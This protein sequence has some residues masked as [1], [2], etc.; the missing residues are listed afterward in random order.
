MTN[1]SGK[2][3]ISYDGRITG[4]RTIQG[5]LIPTYWDV[6]IDFFALVPEDEESEESSTMDVTIAFNVLSFW[7]NDI[8]DNLVLLDPSDVDSRNAI[9][10]FS[11]PIMTTPGYPTDDILVKLLH[12]KM[13]SIVKDKLCIVQTKIKSDD[14]GGMQYNFMDAETTLGLEEMPVLHDEETYKSTNGIP[15]WFRKS[16]DC[17]DLVDEDE[18]DNVTTLFTKVN[19][20]DDPLYEYE[21]SLRAQYAGGG[22]NDVLDSIIKRYTEKDGIDDPDNVTV[23][24][25]KDTT[26]KDNND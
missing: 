11:N 12:Y 14:G 18:D 24:P 15:W 5:T 1:K 25:P 6:S 20:E 9:G 17:Y 3:L 2:L 7:L 4:I 13:N 10:S 26:D 23:M 22:A 16:A 8:M 19:K 21:S